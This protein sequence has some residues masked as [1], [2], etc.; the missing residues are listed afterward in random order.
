MLNI[1]GLKYMKNPNLAK[2]LVVIGGIMCVAQGI[3]S[4]FGALT[5][6]AWFWW[7]YMDFPGSGG[8]IW[9][10]GLITNSIILTGLGFLILLSTRTD[11]SKNTKIGVNEIILTILGI[12]GI[13]FGSIVGGA[14][15]IV[16]VILLH[17][18]F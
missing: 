4:I 12:A 2:Q 9:T 18:K 6:F 11:K 3:I 13:I 15:V 7:A 1:V 10:L 16:S 14:L 17:L 8:F 5:N